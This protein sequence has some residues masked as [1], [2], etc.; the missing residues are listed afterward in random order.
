MYFLNNRSLIGVILCFKTKIMNI[1]IITIG[2]EILIGQIV[3]TNSAWMANLLTQEGFNIAAITSVGDDSISISKALDIALQRVD[4]VLMTGGIGPTK[5]DI[6][7]STL[8]RYF[9]SELIFNDSVLENIE[10][11]FRNKNIKLNQ[12]TKNQALVPSCATVIQNLVGTAPLLWFDIDEK[13]LVSMPGVTFEMK[14]AMQL[15]ILPRLIQKFSTEKYLKKIFVVSGISESGLA[16]KLENFENQLPKEFLLAYLPAGGLIRLRLSVK[17]KEFEETFHHQTIILKEELRDFLISEG[18]FSLGEILHHLCAANKFTLATAESCTGGN[19]AHTITRIAGASEYFKGSIVS[20]TNEIKE[21]ILQVNP[22]TLQKFGIVSEQ[23]VEE[24][25]FNCQKIFNTNCSIA[26]SGIA[27]PDGCTNEH[28]VGSIWISTR[29][30][31]ISKS[32]LYHFG[33]VREENIIRAT[34]IAILQMIKQI[35]ANL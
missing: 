17:G 13:V 26:V 30:K 33:K 6:T 3:D 21:N 10:N 24:M 15:E 11:I 14:N 32:E 35:K 8:C 22:S 28:P 1:E 9:H 5:D 16:I 25:S 2:D 29:F 23:T 18:D 34:N 20:Y 31:N 7:K 19:I 4:V 27:G 12:L